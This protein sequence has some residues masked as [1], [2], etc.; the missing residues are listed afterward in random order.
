MDDKYAYDAESI[1][2]SQ[3][4]LTAMHADEPARARLLQTNENQVLIPFVN[5]ALS[6]LSRPDL[7][8]SQDAANTYIGF[9]ANLVKSNDKESLKLF[10]KPALLD[11]QGLK[12]SL[13]R[14][15]ED[16]F[17]AAIHTDSLE[18]KGRLL[19]Q[20]QELI[21]IVKFY[22]DAVKNH[23]KD[24]VAFWQRLK[25]GEF[26]NMLVDNIRNNQLYMYDPPKNPQVKN[27]L[28][29]VN[30]VDDNQ[31]DLLLGFD[32]KLGQD[33]SLHVDL[34]DYS[35]VDKT[36]AEIKQLRQDFYD[37]YQA[38]LTNSP[39]LAMR[40]FKVIADKYANGISWQLPNQEG[41]KNT[42]TMHGRPNL[43]VIVSPAIGE[44]FMLL[45]KQR[46]VGSRLEHE[47]MIDQPRDALGAQKMAAPLRES[48]PESLLTLTQAERFQ[49]LLTTIAKLPPESQRP[50]W[51]AIQAFSMQSHDDV[52]ITTNERAYT[53]VDKGILLKPENG[54]ADMDPN[55]YLY[56][57]PN[58]HHR[59]EKDYANQR[60]I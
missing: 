34:K 59:P 8:H 20:H 54:Q 14:S 18:E 51:H 42:L 35:P 4:F 39:E 55:I 44:Q 1:R 32:I 16:I 23:A 31:T 58:M 12:D 26:E 25:S 37:I 10:A 7:K 5:Q 50:Y 6:R 40:D 48:Q 17:R 28:A 36:P 57:M 43:A 13:P 24:N 2:L 38:V 22:D 52:A 21:H 53:N 30:V 3:V 29:L 27:D 41:N 19:Q 33:K 11:K 9:M 60:S 45:H 46:D 49:A 15:P 56:D 47:S